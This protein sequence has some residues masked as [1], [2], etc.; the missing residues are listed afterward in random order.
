MELHELRVYDFLGLCRCIFTPILLRVFYTY[1][2]GY[3]TPT[4]KGI[5]P[6]S[7]EGGQREWMMSRVDNFEQLCRPFTRSA[8]SGFF[9]GRCPSLAYA[10]LSGLIPVLVASMG[11]AR[12]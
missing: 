11:G 3:F 2:E 10:A 6:L 7:P 4:L 8:Y 9:D 12:R 1:P 5:L